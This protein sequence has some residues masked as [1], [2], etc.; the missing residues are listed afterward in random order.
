MTIDEIIIQVCTGFAGSILAGGLIA[1]LSDHWFS[2][3][4]KV[5]EKSITNA[6]EP[7]KTI[8]SSIA[9]EIMKLSEVVD[10]LRKGLEEKL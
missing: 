9:V 7:V 4:I 8:N 3:S 2:E 10:N 6:L 5:T 1:L